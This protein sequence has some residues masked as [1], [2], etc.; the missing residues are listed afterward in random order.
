MQ[1]ESCETIMD[2]YANKYHII[3]FPHLGY[4]RSLR[5]YAILQRVSR[6]G[7]GQ[8]HTSRFGFVIGLEA[9]YSPE[10]SQSV[11]L[12]EDARECPYPVGINALNLAH[13]LWNDAF[14]LEMIRRLGLILPT[15]WPI[16][17]DRAEMLNC[18]PYAD[19]LRK[20]RQH[21]PL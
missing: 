15:P 18:P 21:Y 13:D 3:D 14:G 5:V 16:A 10:W 11:I 20:N 4:D 6:E 8:S 9:N 19:Y 1:M 7:L 12:G 2:I 17:A